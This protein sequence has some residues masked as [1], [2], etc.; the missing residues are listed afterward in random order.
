MRLVVG[1][2]LEVQTPFFELVGD[3]DALGVFHVYFAV[4]EFILMGLFAFQDVGDVDGTDEAEFFVV[5]ELGFVM[6]G[7]AFDEV[8]GQAPEGEEIGA[9]IGVGGT[10]GF[11]FGIEQGDAFFAAL[12]EDGG[13]FGGQIFGD[14]EFANIMEYAGGKGLV[15]EVS[16]V[17]ELVVGNPAGEEAGL[18]GVFPHFFEG[19]FGA[20]GLIEF[21]E[22]GDGK[23]EGL[24]GADAEEL[25]GFFDGVDFAAEAEEGG[26]AE[27]KE[28]GGEGGVFAGDVGDAIGGGVGGFEGFEHLH[29]EMGGAGQMVDAGGEG[30]QAFVMD[31]AFQ[32]GDAA[33]AVAEFGEVAG[34]LE[35][36]VDDA[37][38]AHGFAEVGVAGED[39]ANGAGM[40]A[41]DLVEEL[42]TVDAGHAHVGDNDI[43]GLL[44]EEFKGAFTGLSIVGIPFFGHGPHGDGENIE[45]GGFVINKQDSYSLWRDARWI[46]QNVR[47]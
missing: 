40:F 19:K 16:A 31:L 42:G 10:K 45:Y 3:A 13:V 38:A 37:D 8:Q 6:V 28:F 9:D 26:V 11:A 14:D 21:G 23:G 44:V 7:D 5:E 39:D 32:G 41:E 25:D 15:G 46:Y 43:E 22:K 33:D 17:G 4:G 2:G 18:G 35:K 34:F 12:F 47:I 36:L 27:V 1:V 24:E 29:V 20:F 30:A